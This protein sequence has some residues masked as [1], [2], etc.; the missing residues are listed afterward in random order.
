MEITVFVSQVTVSHLT[1]SGEFGPS[2]FSIS[3]KQ[4]ARITGGQPIWLFL[5]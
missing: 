5:V 2:A 1:G 4:G 3:E